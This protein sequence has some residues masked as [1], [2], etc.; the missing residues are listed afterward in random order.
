MRDLAAYKEASENAQLPT[1][2]ESVQHL[3]EDSKIEEFMFLG[4]RMMR[5]VSRKEFERRF[6]KSMDEV[7]GEVIAKYEE[8]GLLE[9]ADGWVRLTAKG[10]DVSNMVLVDFLLDI[11]EEKIEILEGEFEREVEEEI[12][13]E[14][15]EAEKEAA[16]EE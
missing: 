2:W 15:E 16:E 8:M 14:Q 9:E 6:K 5:G 13:R 3:K 4:L 10:I 12:R 1:D 11:E 7:Y